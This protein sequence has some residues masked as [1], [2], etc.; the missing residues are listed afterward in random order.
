MRRDRIDG[1]NTILQKSAPKSAPKKV[2]DMY[3]I[4]PEC[5]VCFPTQLPHRET[6]PKKAPVFAIEGANTCSCYPV[7]LLA[8]PVKLFKFGVLSLPVPHRHC[9]N[10]VSGSRWATAIM[11]A[12]LLS[13]VIRRFASVGMPAFREDGYSKY[14]TVL[15]SGGG[16]KSTATK[17]SVPF[18]DSA[19]ATASSRRLARHRRRHAW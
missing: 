10:L 5:V 11:I 12:P 4:K 1:I 15:Y 16:R 2:R 14:V 6:K 9:G 8:T 13:I 18:P 3:E 7:L 17:H 19:G